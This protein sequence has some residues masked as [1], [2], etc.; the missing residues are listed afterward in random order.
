ME[1]QIAEI[2]Q[3]LIEIKAMLKSMQ[4][5]SVQKKGDA[6]VTGQMTAI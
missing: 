2:K 1:Q 5:A 6:E 4:G 3:M